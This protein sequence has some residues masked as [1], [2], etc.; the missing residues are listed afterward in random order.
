MKT[1]LLAPPG[2]LMMNPRT[3][4]EDL[5][6]PKT[7][8][9]LGI[10]YLAS[11]LRAVGHAVEVKDLHDCSWQEVSAL[12]RASAPDVV[13]IS[14]FTMNRA[15]A[16]R[17]ASLIKEELP[18]SFVIMG[19]PHATFFPEHILQNPAVDA[20]A[21]G[22]GEVTLVE[23]VEA[24][25]SDG[26]L[27][28]IQ[29]LVLRKGDELLWTEPRRQLPALDSLPF[30]A[31]EDFPLD[32]YKSS[33]I[34]PQYLALTGTHVLTSRGCPF[35]CDFCSVH[36]YFGGKWHV[37]SPENVLDEVQMLM[38]K[39]GVKHIYFSDDL[40]SLDQARVI[41]LCKMM[42]DR[43]LQLLWMAETRVDCVSEEMLTWMRK[44][45]CYR[46][47]YGVE[48]GSP[49]ILQSMNKGFGVEQIRQAFAMTHAAGIQPC[50]FLMVGN[51]GENPESIRETIALI[52]EIKP[53]QSPIIGINC[54][55]PGTAHYR[56]AQE[57]GVI[58]DEYWMSD[59]PPPLFTVERSSDELIY[60]QI[61]L[62]QGV[63]PEQYAQM[64]RFGMDE[65]Y[66]RQRLLSS[67][68]SG[69]A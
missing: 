19:G 22:Q 32:D 53:T 13:G 30:P 3:G 7:W 48:S 49:R 14:C 37:R 59:L 61:L 43:G 45:G 39:H 29:G 24:L 26:D 8:I 33:E 21:L 64:C 47:Y 57:R 50:C 27:R 62:S 38:E 34:A 52:H 17:L 41:T 42:L 11:S 12:L 16:L 15:N 2:R 20:V 67:Y 44:A 23:V 66:F 40:F 46:V 63:C 54:L 1:L 31:H 60:L 56:L 5:N 58:S 51:P 69:E 35:H 55:F 28:Q 18:A 4:H 65:N 25:Q 68:M 36:D 10:A 9:P 6:L